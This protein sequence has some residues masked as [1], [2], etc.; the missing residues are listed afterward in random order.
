[1]ILDATNGNMVVEIPFKLGKNDCYYDSD[2]HI[3]CYQVTDI[4]LSSLLIID[5]LTGRVIKRKESTNLEH[6]QFSPDGKKIIGLS[7]E[8]IRIEN[9]ADD[10]GSLAWAFPKLRLVMPSILSFS[11]K[12]NLFAIVVR[13]DPTNRNCLVVVLDMNATQPLWVHTFSDIPDTR[14]SPEG[15]ELFLKFKDKVLLIDLNT[16]K[17]RWSKS[18]KRIRHSYFVSDAILACQG[19]ISP[20]DQ[21][22]NYFNNIKFLDRKTGKTILQYSAPSE[23]NYYYNKFLTIIDNFL[24]LQFNNSNKGKKVFF[25]PKSLLHCLDISPLKIASF[26]SQPY[27]PLDQ[28]LLIW[29]IFKMLGKKDQFISTRSLERFGYND[30][31]QEIKRY[32]RSA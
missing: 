5:S 19:T 12:N 25:L 13:D 29:Y 4:R 7:K 31:P 17:E 22:E 24:Y 2:L 32:G 27:I 26:L 10:E 16:K 23:Q 3:V 15:N 1:M 14:F 9:T 30:L 18:R 11:S 6:F 28:A 21:Q 8:L 20:T